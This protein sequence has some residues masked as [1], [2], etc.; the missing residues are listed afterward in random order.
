MN[1]SIE[2]FTHFDFQL[3]PDPS[4]LDLVITESL[5]NNTKVNG[6][7]SGALLPLP[8][9]TGIGKT[10]TALNFLLQ[11]MLA[12]VQNEYR[13]KRVVVDP[14]VCSITLQIQ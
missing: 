7:K 10:Y 3:V 13:K 8:F 2:E 11:Q 12:Q 6:A 4:P 9:Q 5:E 14:S 1:A